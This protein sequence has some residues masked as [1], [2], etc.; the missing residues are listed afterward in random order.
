MLGTIGTI[1]YF[2]G[3]FAPRNWALCNGQLLQIASNTA[4]FSIIGTTYGGDGR[5]TFALPDLR[6]RAS[7]GAGTGPGLPT[8]RLGQS[9]GTETNIM[10][11]QTM[12]SHN[13]TASGVVKAKNGAGDETNPGGGYFATA[14]S[15]LYAEES[16]TDMAADSVSVTVGNTGS[17]TPINNM[18]PYLV[19]NHIICLTGIFPTRS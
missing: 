2:A 18:Q 14:G 4:L 11:I 12:P 1:I 13:H 16:N 6:G 8:Y 7:I 10:S 9:G 17:G 5:V 3:T 19:V 15:D